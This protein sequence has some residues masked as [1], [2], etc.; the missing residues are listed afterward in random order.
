LDLSSSSGDPLFETD[1]S[2]YT[3]W[4]DIFRSWFWRYYDHLFTFII[5]NFGWFI[6]CFGTAWIAGRSGFWNSPATSYWL[7]GLLVLVVEIA[8]TLL[9]ALPVH[10]LAVQGSI[11]WGEYKTKLP[12]YF[13]KGLFSLV[14]AGLFLGLAFFNIRFYLAIQSTFS[15]WVFVLMGFVVTVLVYVLMITFYLWPILFFQDPPL[16]KL[17][18]RSFMVTLSSGPSSLFLLLFS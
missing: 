17:F 4:Q 7:G 1:L 14:L 13:S 6:T 8:L 5:L 9:W 10:L 11:S 16:G 3:R 12:K 15:V 18:Y 2:P